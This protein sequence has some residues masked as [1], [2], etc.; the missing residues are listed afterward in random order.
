MTRWER[1]YITTRKPIFNRQAN[2]GYCHRL[3]SVAVE[4]RQDGTRGI[5]IKSGRKH[6]AEFGN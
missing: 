5:V 3:M 6:L 1:Y 4:G 2:M